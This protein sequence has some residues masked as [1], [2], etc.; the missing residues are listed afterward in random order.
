M[1]MRECFESKE[2][3]VPAD[4][5]LGVSVEDRKHGLPRID[6]LRTIP[7][8][9]RFLS[10]EPLLEDLGALPTRH[11]LGHRR[12]RI[13]PKARPMEPAWVGPSSNH[14]KSKARPSSKQWGG[15]GRT[16]EAVQEHS[17]RVFAGKRYSM[18]SLK[19]PVA[20]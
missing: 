6:D 2:R 12:R 11:S 19:H 1:R 5:W 14:A 15:W 7:A 8:A 9:I 13:G 17:G 18:P 16:E 10:V 20:P 4:V 3:Q